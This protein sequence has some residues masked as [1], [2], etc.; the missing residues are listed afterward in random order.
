M[1]DFDLI[2]MM[3]ATTADSQTT[4]KRIAD[5]LRAFDDALEADSDSSVPV[6]ETR[7]GQSREPGYVA[8]TAKSF[9]KSQLAMG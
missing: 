7:T 1:A 4:G 6:N 5:K 2:P 3:T 8:A 9:V